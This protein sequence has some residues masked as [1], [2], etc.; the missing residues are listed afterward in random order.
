MTTL[1][2]PASIPCY[3]ARPADGGQLQV[4]APKI[5]QWYCEPK[6]NGWRGFIHVK[7]GTMF[8]RLG[9]LSS[10]SHEFEAAL[11]KVKA[12]PL[13]WLDVEALERRH[14]IGRG[15]LVVLDYLPAKPDETWLER[16]RY[17]S[18]VAS[19]SGVEIYKQLD[20]PM[21]PDTVYLTPVYEWEGAESLYR[22][23]LPRC[24]GR[25]GL[26]CEFYEGIVAKKANSIYPRQLRNPK[27]TTPF[28]IKHRWH[29]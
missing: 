20:T 29:F 15:T 11:D 9:E 7:T 27:Q 1:F 10:I 4:A 22:D 26:N 2:P 19:I 12:W 13:D 16:R 14:G 21:A 28:W 5:G 6:F 17:L 23:I 25:E 3:P 18:L 24:N 8:N